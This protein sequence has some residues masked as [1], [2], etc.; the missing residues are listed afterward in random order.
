MDVRSL[1]KQYIDQGHITDKVAA[2]REIRKEC[3]R[4]V[5]KYQRKTS[6]VQQ[7]ICVMSAT[8]TTLISRHDSMGE[9]GKAYDAPKA[10]IQNAIKRKSLFRGQ[11][12]IV[13]ESDLP[14]GW[15]N[16]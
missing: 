15:T 3:T 8:L 12:R 5:Y 11:Y 13:K 16:R 10:T 4:L 7:P 9:C 1:I 6:R 14:K 2:L